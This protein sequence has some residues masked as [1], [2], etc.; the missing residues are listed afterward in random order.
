MTTLD[1]ILL[2]VLLVVF[3]AA[4]AYWAHREQKRKLEAE[5]TDGARTFLPDALTEQE[6]QQYTTRYAIETDDEPDFFSRMPPSR[7]GTGLYEL[8]ETDEG[9]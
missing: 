7:G 4:C 2:F 8:Y 3:P 6:L 9:E 1:I 5:R